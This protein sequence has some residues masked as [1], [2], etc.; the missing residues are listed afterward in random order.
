MNRRA[1]IPVSALVFLIL[2]TLLLIAIATYTLKPGLEAATRPGI[3]PEE[4]R[5]LVAWYRLLLTVV[6]FILFA[7]LVLTVRIGRFFFP[8][9]TTP[10]VRTKHVD[11]WAESAKRMQPPPRETERPAGDDAGQ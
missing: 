9:P 1:K 6:L 2:F 5:R 4:K 10:R 7:G 11:A 8:R 3:T